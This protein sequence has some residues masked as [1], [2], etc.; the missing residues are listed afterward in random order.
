MQD[1]NFS[2]SIMADQTQAEGIDIP[3]RVHTYESPVPQNGVL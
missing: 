3:V 1:K 2:T